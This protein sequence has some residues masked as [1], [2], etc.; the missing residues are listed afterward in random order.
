MRL[1][2]HSSFYRLLIISIASCIKICLWIPRK[3]RCDYRGCNNT[4]SHLLS[5]V[6]RKEVLFR[7]WGYSS[8]LFV[9]IPS[10]S[11]IFVV[12]SNN[13]IDHLIHISMLLVLLNAD[14]H[15]AWNF[16]SALFSVSF[17]LSLVFILIYGGGI[18][19]GGG[20]LGRLRG[21]VRSRFERLSWR[22]FRLD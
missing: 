2:I 18:G 13:D 10:I 6:L 4:I 12:G 14:N 20:C 15:T 5:G 7:F 19:G 16:R 21:D 9:R 17:L 8:I 22:R 3:C 1:Q 11:F